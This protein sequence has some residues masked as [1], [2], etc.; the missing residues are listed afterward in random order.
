[1]NEF[2]MKRSE[3]TIS[4]CVISHNKVNNSRNAEQHKRFASFF[5]FVTL[6]QRF[7]SEYAVEYSHHKATQLQNE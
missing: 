2:S 1:M 4:H 7:L 6:S 5:H 3:Y